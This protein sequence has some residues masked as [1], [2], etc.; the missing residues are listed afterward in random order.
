MDVIFQIIQSIHDDST[1]L[2]LKSV[3]IKFILEYKLAFQVILFALQ[4][5]C[6]RSSLNLKSV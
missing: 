4:H 1:Y 6:L 5:F 3:S 2:V